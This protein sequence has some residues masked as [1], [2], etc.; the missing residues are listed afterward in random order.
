[1]QESFYWTN[2][3]MQLYFNGNSGIHAVVE[4]FIQFSLL[5]KTDI[6]KSLI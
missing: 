3:K 1:M 6:H 5:I 2:K 4:K